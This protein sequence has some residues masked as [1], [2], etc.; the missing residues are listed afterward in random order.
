MNRNLR[1]ALISG[2]TL[3]ALLLYGLGG[4]GA[5]LDPSDL[6]TMNASD[7][8]ADGPY[9]RSDAPVAFG[10]GTSGAGRSGDGQRV[11]L[12]DRG[13]QM[14]MGTQ[15]LPEGWNL[16]QDLATDPQTGQAARHTLDVRGPNGELI[17]ALGVVNYGPTVGAD[18][19]QAW[20]QAAMR[21]L[22]DEVEGLAL[23]RL[24][25]SRTVESSP[26]Y[27]R[28]APQAAQH[29]LRV[30]GLEAP[31][32]GRR[33]GEVVEGFVYLTHF[34]SV[35]LRDAGTIQASVLVS[36]AGR[37]AETLRLNEQM[38]KSYRPNPAHQQRV[39]QL[40]QMA[41]RQSAARHQQW[42]ANHQAQM[43]Q[44]TAAHQQRMANSRAQ[45]NA[46][47]QMMQG[48][49]NAADQQMQSWQAGQAS[50]D[51]MHRRT[52]NSINGTADVYDA[53][54][55]ETHYGVEGGSGAYWTDP[56]G[57]SVVGTDTYSDNPDPSRYN[58][59]TNLD[60]LYNS[61]GSGGG[62]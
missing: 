11:T 37:L 51:E 5:G 41:S 43:Q 30:E 25:R 23:G 1:I 36:P 59:G 39:Q 31:F 47:Q 48:R 26:G 58:S 61:G 54:T 24:Q 50:S 8:Y 29:G 3:L 4:P 2:A 22:Q 45:F 17:R 38:A 16:V 18:L 13:L 52:I 42:M 32:R 35:Q 53:Q 46:H 14:P 9:G 56:V 55:G 10:D 15:S 49:W 21:G 19:E 12:V 44:S 60:D 57:G 34:A 6:S 40:G 20:Q 33:R 28:I 7:P 62:E 27:R